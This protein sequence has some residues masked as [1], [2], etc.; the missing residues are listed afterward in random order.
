MVQY[1]V[2]FSLPFFLKQVKGKAVFYAAIISEGL[3][4]LVYINK[5]VTFLWLNVIGAVLVLIFAALL[6]YFVFDNNKLNEA[7]TNPE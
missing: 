5:W 4:L 7:R 1:S 3:V 2:F 6:Q